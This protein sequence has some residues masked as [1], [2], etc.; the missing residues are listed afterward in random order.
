[1]QEIIDFGSL[2]KHSTGS[3]MWQIFVG[4]CS[5][6]CHQQSFLTS[7]TANRDLTFVVAQMATRSNKL[8]ERN[9]INSFRPVITITQIKDI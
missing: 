9:V 5:E 4:L 6:L 7:K 1:M 2:V 3:V 8:H